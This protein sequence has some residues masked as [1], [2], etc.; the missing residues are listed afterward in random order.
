MAA[1]R[2]RASK[3]DN[4]DIPIIALTV[5]KLPGDRERCF[6]AGMNDYL[7][8][9]YEIAALE[10]KIRY[11]LSARRH[12]KVSEQYQNLGDRPLH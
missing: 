1:A 6:D 3:N 8:K 2:I 10:S 7:A 9:P 12:P 11:W 5:A 4:R